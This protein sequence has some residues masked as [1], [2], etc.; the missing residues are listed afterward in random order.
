MMAL[1]FLIFFPLGAMTIR[2]VRA[3]GAVWVHAGAQIFAY[4]LALA[5]FGLGVWF[6]VVTGKVGP[7][8]PSLASHPLPFA[9]KWKRW[10]NAQQLNTAHAIVGIVVIGMMAF[11]PIFGLIHHVLFVKHGKRTVFA[12]GHV[13]IGRALLTLGVINGGLGLQLARNSSKGEIVYGVVAG[14]VLLT[15]IL[16]VSMASGGSNGGGQQSRPNEKTV[17]PGNGGGISQSRFDQ[18]KGKDLEAQRSGS[19]HSQLGPERSFRTEPLRS[20]PVDGSLS[21]VDRQDFGRQPVRTSVIRLDAAEVMEARSL[22]IPHSHSESGNALEPQL[23]PSMERLEAEQGME[24]QPLGIAD[25][26]LGSEHAARTQHLHSQRDTQ[27]LQGHAAEPES[28]NVDNQNRPNQPESNTPKRQSVVSE[29]VNAYYPHAGILPDPLDSD[30]PMSGAVSGPVDM[31]YPHSAVIP[32]PADEEYALSGVSHGPVD[33][34]YPVDTS[35]S[36][37]KH[38]EA[39]GKSAHRV[40]TE[41][42]MEHPRADTAQSWHEAPERLHGHGVTYTQSHIDPDKDME[43]L[44]A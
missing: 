32:E 3:K 21:R 43:I 24:G 14:L 41:E 9:L 34:P 33:A 37:A 6:A 8:F 4:S 19:S 29:L 17:T 16:V 22:D 12:I 30:Y 25:G 35:Y 15:Y 39:T 31:N 27:D 36:H 13:W 18:R 44:P 2:F 28:P 5:A 23:A 40:E 10:L 38:S 20:Q 7:C 1:A 26:Q 42:I 11:M